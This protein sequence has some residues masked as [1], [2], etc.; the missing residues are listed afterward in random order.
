[1]HIILEQIFIGRHLSKIIFKSRKLLT[2]NSPLKNNAFKNKV[3]TI[4]LNLV[5]FF[6][7]FIIQH[8]VIGRY[9]SVR[10]FKIAIASTVWSYSNFSASMVEEDISRCR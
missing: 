4:V 1:M 8:I 6:S 3:V 9:R 10:I 5:M 2:W 7:D